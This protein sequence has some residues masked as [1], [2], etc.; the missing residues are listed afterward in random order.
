MPATKEP[1]YVSVTGLKAKSFLST[2]VFWRH[3]IPSR[4][5]AKQANGLV[6]L[7]VKR[8]EQYQHTLSV[9]KNKDAMIAYRDSGAH[10]VAIKGFRKIA[11]G[12]VYGFEA[13]SIPSWEVALNLWTANASDV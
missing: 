4:A 3:A 7:E 12:K 5:Q 2:F 11:T 10:L 13:N 8:V 1:Y 9:W 6:F